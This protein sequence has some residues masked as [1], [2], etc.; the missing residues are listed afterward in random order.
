MAEASI[1]VTK[2]IKE[3][4]MKAKGD[5]TYN[6]FFKKIL[7]EKEGAIIDDINEV[8]RPQ[9]AITIEYIGLGGN[10]D[11]L[12]P[13]QTNEYHISFDDLKNSQVGDV[14]HV[15][16]DNYEYYT[17]ESAE[18]VF[19]DKDTCLLRVKIETNTPEAYR[20]E[21]EMVHIELF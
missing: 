6:D 8:K 19:K 11:A 14:F 7:K 15:E 21:Y 16:D 13:Y 20:K 3:E 9:T 12:H 5:M 4:I 1:P 10:M 17:E 18:V 2:K